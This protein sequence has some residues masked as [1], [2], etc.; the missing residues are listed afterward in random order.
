METRKIADLRP[1]AENARIYGDNAA[2]LELVTSVCSKGILQALLVTWDNRV[3]SGHRRLIA[4]AAAKLDAVPVT[5][6]RSRDELDILEAL[7]EANRQRVKT[8]EQLGREALVLLEVEEKRALRRMA[9]AG[10][11]AAPGRPAEKGKERVPDLSHAGQSRDKVGEQLGVSGKHAEKA[12]SVV[13]AIDTL[14]KDGR[15]REAEQLRRTLNAKSVGAAYDRAREAGHIQPKARPERVSLPTADKGPEYVTLENWNGLNAEQRRK[16]MG[17]RGSKSMNF[18]DDNN[19]EWS[20]WSWNPVTGCLHNCPYC[21]ARDIAVRYYEPRFS[22][23][24]W[25]GRLDAPLNVKVPGEAAGQVGYKNVFVCSMADLFGRWVPM[26]WIEAVL[27]T[28]RAAPQ[29]NFLFLTKFPIRMAE[30]KFPDN[31]WVGTTVDCQARVANAERA[32]RKV[33]AGVKWLSCEPLIEPLKFADLGA[34]DWVVLGGASRSTQTPEWRPPRA[35]VNA[36]Q[37]D[38]DRLGVKVYEKTNLLDRRREYPGVEP[39]EVRQSPEGL[40]YLPTAE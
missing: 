2:D 1:H 35:W 40:R 19:I 3:I 26:E 33:K 7:V 5:V 23:T 16:L 29:W 13:E 24:L 38:A 39:D 22:P 17:G 36:I 15:E 37:A 20:L 8:N 34:F 25:P 11:S 27:E 9:E 21:Y 12:A 6:F 18:Q 28:V 30:F 31:A 4:A 14:E 10:K 32:F